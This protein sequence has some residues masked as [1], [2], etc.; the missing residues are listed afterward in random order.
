[1]PSIILP[2]R[3]PS[4]PVAPD[5]TGRLSR[6]SILGGAAGAVASLVAG[7]SALGQD[8]P[9]EVGLPPRDGAPAG[10]GSRLGGSGTVGGAG[11]GGGEIAARTPAARD[12]AANAAEP[13]VVNGR[14][15][16]AYIDAFLKQGQWDLYTCEFDVAHNIMK[17][18]DVE[19][20]LDEMVSIVGFDNPFEPYAVDGPDGPIIYGGDI[21]KAFCG[22]LDSNTFSKCSGQAMI[23][24]FEAFGFAPVVAK[25][26]ADIEKGLSAGQLLWMKTTVDF[27]AWIPTRWVTPDGTSHPTVYDNDHCVGAVGYNDEVV[28]IHDALGP[29][30]TNWERPYEYEVPW[31]LFMD[32]FR[33]SG[34]D[35]LLVGPPTDG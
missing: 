6:R 29:T 35:G 33:S 14:S 4:V 9:E 20:T 1:M 15:Y 34:H 12:E 32:C 31:D 2:P 23:P 19:T 17:T 3:S 22:Y 11:A 21:K 24:A 8:A 5:Q 30:N 28:V 25:T 26:R 13:V 18:F 7:R 27:T 16:T 10:G